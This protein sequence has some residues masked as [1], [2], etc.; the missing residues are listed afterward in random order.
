VE[1]APLGKFPPPWKLILVVAV[2]LAS[3]PVVF[4]SGVPQFGW[5]FLNLYEFHHCEYRD[6]PYTE[7]AIECDA[8][9]WANGLSTAPVLVVHVGAMAQL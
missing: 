6:T 4:I 1:N 2:M 9:A 7:A 8:R 5:D 3:T